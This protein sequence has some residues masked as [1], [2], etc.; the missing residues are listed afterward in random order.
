MGAAELAGENE[1]NKYDYTQ[2]NILSSKQQNWFNRQS[3]K[4]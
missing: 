2:E 1:L 4:R 3:S